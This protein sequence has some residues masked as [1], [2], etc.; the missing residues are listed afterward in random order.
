MSVA[1]R[2]D[3]LSLNA[4]PSRMNSPRPGSIA[5]RTS[6]RWSRPQHLD[7]L[8][9]LRLH[10]A[11]DRVLVNVFLLGVM[12]SHKGFD[13][14]NYAFAENRH[15]NDLPVLLDAEWPTIRAFTRDS[16]WMPRSELAEIIS[17]GPDNIVRGKPFE[18]RQGGKSA[19]WVRTRRYAPP[20]SAIEISG[21][22]LHTT[23]H[24]TLLTAKVPLEM[25]ACVGHLPLRPRRAG[26]RSLLKH[27]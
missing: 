13:Q 22:I 3:D 1:L 19:V 27:G 24:G 17:F 21:T 11:A 4:K 20:G 25:T 9:I 12:N 16:Y 26:P 23:I 18:M 8:L 6:T 2:P 15:P 10:R 7:E 5:V 14:L